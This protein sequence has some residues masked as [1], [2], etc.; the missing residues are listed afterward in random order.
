V[1]G[2][3][4]RVIGAHNLDHGIDHAAHDR[5]LDPEDVRMAH[6]ATKDPAQHVAPC[7]VRREHAVADEQ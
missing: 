4:I 3:E 2:G 6:G 1:V 7:L 5:R